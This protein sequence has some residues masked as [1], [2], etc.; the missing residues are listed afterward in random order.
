MGTR[1]SKANI[2]EKC[3][4]MLGFDTNFKLRRENN[5]VCVLSA[6]FLILF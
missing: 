4:R 1:I 3:Y 5:S 6:C 2:E